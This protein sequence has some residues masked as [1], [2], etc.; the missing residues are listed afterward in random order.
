MLD[1]KNSRSFLPSSSR[2]AEPEALSAS[3][4]TNEG[5]TRP[6]SPL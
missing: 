4:E 3:S 2:R 1:E 6:F 5:E